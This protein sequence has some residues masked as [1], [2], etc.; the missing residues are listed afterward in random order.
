M[1]GNAPGSTAGVTGRGGSTI[2]VRALS[3]ALGAAATPPG[4]GG[5]PPNISQRNATN[6]IGN[7]A[8]RPLRSGGAA[9][10]SRFILSANGS[11]AGGL[12]SEGG[13]TLSSAAGSTGSGAPGMGVGSSGGRKPGGGGGWNGRPGGKGCGA[14]GCKAANAVGSPSRLFGATSGFVLVGVKP[15]APPRLGTTIAGRRGL[16]AL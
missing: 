13:G 8:R 3:D 2:V 15:V 7:T 6:A 11:D 14:G 4:A 9:A 12:G 16:V 10:H 1:I 5:S